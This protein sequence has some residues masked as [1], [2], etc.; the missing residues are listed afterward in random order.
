MPPAKERPTG[1]D[2][3]QVAVLGARVDSLDEQTS[4]LRRRSECTHDDVAGLRTDVAVI[5]TDVDA[6]KRRLDSALSTTSQV[7][8]M[9]LTVAV[10]AAAT[11]LS[12]HA[13]SPVPSAQA[14]QT[15]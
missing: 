12:S 6:I 3:G 1:S 7:A 4:S 8:I 14:H 2:F 11:Y 9:L 10:T 13:T 5:R 15:R